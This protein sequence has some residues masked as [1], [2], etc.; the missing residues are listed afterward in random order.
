MPAISTGLVALVQKTTFPAAVPP[1]VPVPAAVVPVSAAVVPV[2]A[3]V[4][5]VS[6]P[7]VTAPPPSPQA[8]TSNASTANLAKYFRLDVDKVTP[9]ASQARVLGPLPTDSR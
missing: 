9:P 7:V 3:M 6:A 1:V 2:S 5:P 4:V 8:A